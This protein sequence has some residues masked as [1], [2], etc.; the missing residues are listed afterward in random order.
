[1]TDLRAE[2]PADLQAVVLRC[3]EKDPRRR[4]AEV[5]SLDEALAGCGS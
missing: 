1:L 5:G 4:F 2:V 3:L